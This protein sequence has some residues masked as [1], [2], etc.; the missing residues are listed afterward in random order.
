MLHF[1]CYKIITKKDRSRLMKTWEFQSTRNEMWD[2]CTQLMKRN[3]ESKEGTRSRVISQKMGT[4]NYDE[5]LRKRQFCS[6]P[7]CRL[8]SHQRLCWLCVHYIRVCGHSAFR[9]SLN[10]IFMWLQFVPGEKFEIFQRT[11]TIP[12]I[13]HL[14]HM[15]KK[16]LTWLIC[17]ETSFPFQFKILNGAF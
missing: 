9:Y 5:G 3:I 16:Y 2:Y 17:R 12:V 13:F 15:H 7:C 11:G 4:D 6:E 10:H 8:L 14:N 1:T